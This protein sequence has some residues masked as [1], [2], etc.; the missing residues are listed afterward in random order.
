MHFDP[1]TFGLQAANFL[2]L[3]WLLQRF[4]YRPVLAIIAER[5]AQARKRSD[6]VEAARKAVEAERQALQAQAQALQAERDGA[7]AATRQA[8]EAERKALLDKAR[9]EGESIRAEAQD[10]FER[11]RAELVRQAGRDAARLASAVARRLAGESAAP[12]IQDQM[13]ALVRQDVAAMDAEAR[14]RIAGRLGAGGGGVTVVTA[15]ELEPE[16][17]TRF[18]DGLAEA[19]GAAVAP[20]FRTDPALI[21]GVEVRFPYTILRRSW[22]ESL[23]RIEAELTD[24]EPAAA[25]A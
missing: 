15:L 8:G 10:A 6:E 3:V 7:L 9:A 12:A 1:W 13:L 21:A 20:E 19:L 23:K 2:I 11:E 18:A 25:V 17:R 5:Q 4:L 24:D 14:G 22:A 16:A